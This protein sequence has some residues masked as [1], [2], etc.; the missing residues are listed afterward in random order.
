[1]AKK[2]PKIALLYDFDKTLSTKDMQEYSFIPNIGMSAGEFWSKANDLSVELKMDR[3]LAYMYL[4]IKEATAKG[5]PIRRENF[6][7]LGRDIEF[8]PG[9]TTWF[10]R[11]NAFGRE[12]GVEI[13]HYIISSGLKEIIE[14]SKIYKE[15]KKIYAC[16]FHY[17]ENGIADWPLLA[18]NYTAKTQFPYRINKGVLDISN[19]KDLNNHVAEDDRPV[20]FRNMIYLGDGLTDVPCMKLVKSNGGQAIAVYTKRKNVE[21]LLRYSRVN[22]IAPAN[23]GANGY[24]ESLV[25]EIIVQMASTDFLV[26]KSKN[27]VKRLPE[28]AE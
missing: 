12:H 4:M 14:G 22:Y 19:D 21:D 25:K 10:D 7:Q 11:I 28:S 2:T 18:V 24:L 17:N 15:F 23:Y 9:V 3:I 20:P 8:F 1:M 27:Q 13:Q 16:E 5:V 26:R 6:V